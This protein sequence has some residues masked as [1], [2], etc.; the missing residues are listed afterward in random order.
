MKVHFLRHAESIFNATGTSEK[1]C[2]L[3][4]KG[5]QQASEIKNQYDLV[6]CSTMKRACSTLDHS[7]LTYGRL[8]FTDLCRE[9][10]VDICDFLPDEDETLLETNNK[11]NKRIRSFLYFLK[12]QASKHH[13][14]LII[15]HRDFI[16][17]IGKEL[18]PPPDNAELQIHDV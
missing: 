1:D 6:I 9:K 15:S 8:I 10:K 17:A 11:L 13:N 3:S 7:H 2:D 16:H 12:S 5:K 4:E 18:Q 14:I